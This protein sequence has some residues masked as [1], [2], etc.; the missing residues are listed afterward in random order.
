MNSVIVRIRPALKNVRLGDAIEAIVKT[1]DKAIRYS[2]EDYAVVFSSKP[3]DAI[4]LETRVFRLNPGLFLENLRK[5]MAGDVS[6][7]VVESVRRFFE[8]AGVQVVPPNVFYYNDRKGLL[9]VR[10]TAKELDLVQN[11]LGLLN[12]SPQLITL[13]TKFMEIPAEA[14][15]KIGLTLPLPAEGLQTWTKFLTAAQARTTLRA[16]EQIAGAEIL[17]G[18][19][20]TTLSG[21]QTQIQAL[22][23]RPAVAGINLEVITPFDH[24]SSRRV[25]PPPNALSSPGLDVVAHVADDGYTVQLVAVAS[26]SELAAESRHAATQG[27]RIDREQDPPPPFRIHSRVATAEIYD[28]QTLVF[29][30]T[31]P[32]NSRR[33]KVGPVPDQNPAGRAKSLVIFITPTIIDP[34]GHPIHAPGK[35]PFPAD[36]IP[37]QTAR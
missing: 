32:M 14:A 7:N 16:A 10:A 36:K 26:V 18:P 6:T 1:A 4:Q 25:G 31:F 28:G 24:N 23:F 30:P 29:A 37:P 3:A 11:A 12:Y 9:M 8:S 2:I 22:E 19:K 35:E 21:R 13:E 15:R 34:A 33:R 20:V 27:A 17:S 5:Q